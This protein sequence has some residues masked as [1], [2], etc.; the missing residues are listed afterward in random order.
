MPIT[1]G[2]NHVA[3]LTTDMEQASACLFVDAADELAAA[4]VAVG[5]HVHPPQDT[6]WGTREGA[7][8]DPD[9]NV[10]RFGSPMPR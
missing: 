2:F 10:I 6:V 1:T 4:W 7:V 3:T 8:V 9:G 5:V